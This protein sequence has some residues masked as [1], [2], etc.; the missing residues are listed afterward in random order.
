MKTLAQYKS[1]VR[2]GKTENGVTYLSAPSWD[3]NWYWG[4]GYLGN[5]N[6]H[7]H[8]DGLNKEKNLHDAFK[9]HFGE[10]FIVKEDA[11]IW[12][13]AELF[14]SFYTLKAT[15]E[16]YH[17]GGAHYTTNPCKELLKNPEQEKH[18]NEVLLPAIFHAIYEILN[19]YTPCI[20]G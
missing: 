7:Y 3:C 10:S 2:L 18:I 5:R 1:K 12:E 13:L 17:I 9:E 16:F 6:C 15:A 14:K 20:E 19:K 11:D 8:V 4:F